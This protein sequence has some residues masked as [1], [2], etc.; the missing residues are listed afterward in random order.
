[1]RTTR[2]GRREQV[3]GR[4]RGGGVGLLGL[5]VAIRRSTYLRMWSDGTPTRYISCRVSW[6][7]SSGR[8]RQ[9]L[10]ICEQD[11]RRISYLRASQILAV[12]GLHSA[13]VA[14]SETTARTRAATSYNPKFESR[15]Y[16]KT[17]ASSVLRNK[18]NN[19][20]IVYL[21]SPARSSLNAVI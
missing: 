9:S 4:K 8:S 5:T 21:D 13:V 17:T 14:A 2:D 18:I 6:S 20:L 10:V 12:L 19:F 15:A 16:R 11:F 1:M 7:E 3:R